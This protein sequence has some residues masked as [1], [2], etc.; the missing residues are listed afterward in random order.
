V[1][2]VFICVLYSTY[3]FLIFCDYSILCIEQLSTQGWTDETFPHS[4]LRTFDLVVPPAPANQ[5]R[6][7][8]ERISKVAPRVACIQEG[9]FRKFYEPPSSPGL[10]P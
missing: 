7:G 8:Y 4:Q 5:G 9:A 10:L 2:D 1:S 6:R 3:I